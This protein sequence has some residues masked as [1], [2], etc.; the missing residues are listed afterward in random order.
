MRSF[1]V[2]FTKRAVADFDDALRWYSERSADAAEKWIAAVEN[3]LD[4]LEQNPRR[5]PLAR[6]DGLRSV[7]LH[8]CA[9]GASRRKTHR[10]IF[11]IRPA[12]VV[13]YSIYHASRKDLTVDDLL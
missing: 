7:N 11:A 13:V 2:E 6:E 3:A 5:F 1:E 8:E 9:V 12:K 4:A 10:L